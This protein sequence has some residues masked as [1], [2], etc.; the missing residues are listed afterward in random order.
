VIL[1]WRLLL[2]HLL[3]DFPLQSEFVDTWKRKGTWGMVAH[4]AIH[5]AASVL[6]CWPFLDDLWVDTSLFRFQGWT[7]VL[8]VTIA[9]YLEDEWRVFAILKHKAPDN[10]IFFLWDQVV[11]GAVLGT[12]L[13]VHDP[14][15]ESGFL[16]EKW[17]VLACLAVFAVSVAAKLAYYADKDRFDSP[18]PVLDERW[19]AGTER[20]LV[21]AAFLLPGPWG[22]AVPAALAW[23]AYLLRSRLRLDY[24]WLGF[25]LGGACAAG[26]GI[27][28]RAVWYS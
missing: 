8:L 15:Y 3:A 7:C 4:A 9:H 21:F 10:T 24:S 13:T 5:L 14:W 2:G 16:P 27:L 22:W 18:P 11:H 12:L 28:A 23:A 26:A 6:L 1:F 25:W 20:T 19:V 17:P